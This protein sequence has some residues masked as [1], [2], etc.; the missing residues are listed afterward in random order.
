MLRGSQLGKQVVG[1]LWFLQYLAPDDFSQEI[2]I[3][4]RIHPFGRPILQLGQMTGAPFDVEG[5]DRQDVIESLG[6]FSY[7]HRIILE[8]GFQD[9]QDVAHRVVASFFS[10]TVA[11]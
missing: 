7:A 5:S 10:G 1:D 8:H 2:L 3:L 9:I 11:K 4:Q 6:D